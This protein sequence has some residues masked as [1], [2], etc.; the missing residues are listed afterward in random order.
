MD[1]PMSFGDADEE[2][3]DALDGVHYESAVNN[4]KCICGEE[5]V[6]SNLWMNH[7]DPIPEDLDEVTATGITPEESRDL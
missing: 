4:G 3:Q 7:P 6:C 5:W 2:A 1:H